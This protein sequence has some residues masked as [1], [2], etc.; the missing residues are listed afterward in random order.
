MKNLT[1]KLLPSPIDKTTSNNTIS[2]D[3]FS[4]LA[5]KLSN[6]IDKKTLENKQL[7][8]KQILTLIGAGLFLA[9][10]LVAPNISLLA[11]PL[12]KKHSE[13]EY[14]V[15][16]RFNIPYL[17]RTLKRLEQQKLIEIIGQKDTQVV[18][19]TEQGKKKTMK[20]AIDSLTIPKPNK[21]DKTWRLISYDIPTEERQIRHIFYEYLHAWHF[22]PLH[23]SVLLH[24]YPCEE[25]AT[26]LRT[27]L[28]I[29]KYVRIF[30]V[31]KIENDKPFRDFFGV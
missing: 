27:Y 23:E 30:T 16:K 5:L 2:K 21:W 25:Q 3:Y 9:G 17:K 8:S 13:L 29:E 1:S 19:I 31:S 4:E 26:F 6:Q 28:G 12:L 15:W 22:Y 14:E 18:I 20:F 24:A 10:S 11:K 7:K